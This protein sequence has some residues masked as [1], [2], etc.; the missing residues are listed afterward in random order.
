M[1]FEGTAIGSLYATDSVNHDDDGLLL[2]DESAKLKFYAN[3]TEE[4]AMDFSDD[5]D[6]DVNNWYKVKVTKNTDG[7]NN[8]TFS[9][10]GGGA[11]YNS[12]KFR[13]DTTGT[14]SINNF[15]TTAGDADADGHI[16]TEGLLDM[17]Y[18]GIGTTEEATGMVRFKETANEGGTKYEREFR[19]GYGM[20]PVTE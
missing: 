16:K 13:E 17:G 19:A 4:L 5:S 18:Y 15:T 1:N 3:G 20:K 6:P 8:I 14:V 7:S 2:V 9:D 11:S 10:F 12:Y